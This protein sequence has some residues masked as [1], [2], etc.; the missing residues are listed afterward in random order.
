MRDI[1]DIH[2]VDAGLR[3]YDDETGYEALIFRSNIVGVFTYSEDNPA[4]VSVTPC[5]GYGID[6][7][8]RV[9]HRGGAFVPGGLLSPSEATDM[10]DKLIREGLKQ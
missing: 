8:L 9:N 2:W 1:T 7:A 10:L 5:T 6:Y 4:V 3:V